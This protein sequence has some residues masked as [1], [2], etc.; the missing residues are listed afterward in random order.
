MLR[1]LLQ[2]IANWFVGIQLEGLLVELARHG[3]ED[4]PDAFVDLAVR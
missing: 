3:L 2:G 1:L 4:Q